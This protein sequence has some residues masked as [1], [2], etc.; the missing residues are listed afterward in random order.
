M[1]RCP[2][3]RSDDTQVIGYDGAAVL[4]ACAACCA[5]WLTDVK[6]LPDLSNVHTED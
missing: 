3:C 1:R 4:Y 2:E 6:S 5:E